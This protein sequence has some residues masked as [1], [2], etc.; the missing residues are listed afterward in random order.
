MLRWL[1]ELNGITDADNIAR[2]IKSRIKSLKKEQSSKENK[3]EI[4]RL[5]AKLDSVQFKPDYMELIIDST[6]DYK[7]ACKGFSINGVTYKRLVGTSGGLKNS[8]IVFVSERY[9]D[10]IRKRIENGRRMSDEFIPAKLEAY[11]AL[12]CSASIPVSDPHGILV[13]HDCETTF[14]SDYIYLDDNGSSEPIMELKKN[15]DVTIDASDGFGLM[16]PALA[17]RWSQELELPYVMS[18]CCIRNA[19]VKGMVFPFDFVEFAEKVAHAYEVKDVWGS[20]VDIRDVELILTESQLKLWSSYDSLEDYLNFCDENSYT[21]AVTKTCPE[22]LES[23]RTSNYQFI[24]PFDLNDEDIQELIAPTMREIQDVLGGDWSKAALFLGGKGMNEKNVSHLEDSFLKA[25]MIDHRTF[26]DPYVRGRIYN[27]IKGRIQEAKI[28]VLNLHG[29]YSVVSGDPY[30]LMQSVFGMK[31]TGLLKACEIYNKYWV[32]YG[33]E[34]LLCFRAPMSCF[35][36]IREVHVA[37]NEEAE[38]WYQYMKTVTVISCWSMEMPA[39]NG[40]DFDGDLVF[41]TDNNVLL[42]R[43]YD[44]P[45]ILCIQKKGTKTVPTEDDLMKSNI[46][47]FGNDIGKITNRVTTMYDLQSHYPA[48]SREYKVL[49]YRIKCGQLLQQQAIDKF[50]GI[51]SEPM[52]KYWYDYHSVNKIEDEEERKFQKSIMA[53]HKP[54]FMKYIYPQLMKDYNDY[55]HNTDRNA[56][57]E[58]KMTVEELKHIPAEKLTDKQK[59]FLHYFDLGLPVSVGNCVMNRICRAFESEFDGYMY[60]NRSRNDFDYSLYKS[61]ASYTREQYL[62]VQKLYN[63]YKNRVKSYKVFNKYER[64]DPDE[65]VLTL[66]GFKEEFKR[67]LEIE[68]PNERELCD[69]LLDICY[70]SSSAKYLVWSLYA[71]VIC[72][73]LLE[74]NGY[75]ITA[76]VRDAEGQIQYAGEHFALL[77]QSL[78]DGDAVGNSAE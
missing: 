8:T 61:N 65:Y 64:V 10:E 51:V 18:G 1:D 69:I 45:A 37:H 5:Y 28:G 29:N 25:L 48:D 58:F 75:M 60:E 31:V 17:E 13:V 71:D 67:N 50:K 30:A 24:Q 54:Y 62:A 68:V 55:I 76:P 16:R 40:M 57:W 32:D 33:S 38:Y 63:E 70:R 39:L 20:T 3:K 7:K 15:E 41:L 44:T 23:E 47:G 12:A 36:N 46:D 53:E 6:K 26:E 77:T 4:R 34:K 21:F 74:K 52:P 42:R 49:D 73:N 11:R 22:V 56:L 72:E 66:E 43:Y 27:L 35:N 78:R 2:D 19:F 14:K 9:V 59:E